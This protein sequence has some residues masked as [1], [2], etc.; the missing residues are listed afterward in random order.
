MYVL[1]KLVSK[2]ILKTLF[3]IRPETLILVQ[4]LWSLDV[5]I[6]LSTYK[7]D[8]SFGH[9]KRSANLILVIVFAI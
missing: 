4:L 8:G 1:V 6:A 5:Y 3:I 2:E 7:K 9:F